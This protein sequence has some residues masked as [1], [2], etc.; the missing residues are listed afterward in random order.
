VC[1]K[2]GGLPLAIKAVAR[3]MAGITDPKEW[4]FAVGRLPNANGQDLREALYDPLRWSYDALG[5]YDV[6]L[7]LCFVYLSGF[8]E[9]QIIWFE[10][11]IKVLIGEGLLGSYDPFEVG[12]IYF[13]ILADR[14]LIE[15]I[16]RD[17][18]GS[19]VYFRVHDILHDLA[20]QIAEREENFYCRVNKGL[21]ELTE[22]ECPGASRFFLNY[23]KLTSFPKSLRAPEISSLILAGNPNL[24][25]IPRKV[26]RSMVSLKILSL[27][28]TSLQSLPESVGCLKQLVCLGLV[29]VPIT[30][31]PASLTDLVNLE[32]LQLGGS[33]ITELPSDIH[34]LRS[35]RHLGLERCE[36]LQSLPSNISLLT[37]LQDLAMDGCSRVWAKNGQGKIPKMVA[38]I[39]DLRTLT[40]LKK[41]HLDNNGE[42]LCEGTMGSMVQIETLQLRF[43]ALAN[44]PN[45]FF[46][47]S[48]IK[49]LSLKCPC[50]V[51]MDSQFYKFQ[52][53]IWLKKKKWDV[54]PVIA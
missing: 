34:R 30:R 10:H 26:M 20:T 17:V 7:Q 12:R 5:R 47:M 18:D 9:D 8:L 27:N 3:S 21:T 44:L 51:K 41:L 6:N 25:E 40:Q 50:V 38:S 43:T 45:D 53:L 13:N 42:I 2:C 23:N 39:N 54:P 16:L 14:C 28:G 15:P 52:N 4:E 29:G 11:P 36:D 37:S 35:L 49:R 31:L 46:N 33:K 22:N 32:V 48:K 19:V 1:A 24:R